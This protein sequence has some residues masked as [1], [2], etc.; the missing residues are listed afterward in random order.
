MN[1]LV[2]HQDPKRV[3]S[4]LFSSKAKSLEGKKIDLLAN[5]PIFGQRDQLLLAQLPE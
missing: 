5:L 4:C 1:G 2:S 3:S